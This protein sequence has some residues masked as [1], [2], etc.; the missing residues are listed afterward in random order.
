MINSL[1]SEKVMESEAFE[2]PI[3][4]DKNKLFN[5]IKK[6]VNV[7]NSN[8]CIECLFEGFLKCHYETKFHG[9]QVT[10]EYL[11]TIDNNKY[12]PYGIE[13]LMLDKEFE[14]VDEFIARK[15]FS[16]VSECIVKME[17]MVKDK[18]FPN[19]LKYII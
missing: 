12:L 2:E 9:R 7:Y 3:M 15:R 6:R 16:A 13:A 1:E 11:M 5:I 14:I 17:M 10:I 19:D 4:K 8:D 18:V